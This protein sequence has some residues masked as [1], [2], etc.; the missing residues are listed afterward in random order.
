VW[1][2]G[3]KQ[4]GLV[5]KLQVAQNDGLHKIAGVFKMTLVEPLHNLTGILP[6]S[7]VLDKLKHS[8]SLK[9][10][11]TAPNAKTHTILY[12]DP[13]CYWPKFIRP[14]TNLSLSFL[15]LAESTYRPLGLDTTRPWGKLGLTYSTY[16]CPHP[17][18]LQHRSIVF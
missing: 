7:Y 5:Q 9:L 14:H 8:Y 15:K 16:Q 11:G 13:C 12:N 4:K 18:Y 10:Q 3:V 6:I 2:T 1:Y 17:I